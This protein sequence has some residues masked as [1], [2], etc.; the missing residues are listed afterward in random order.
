[1]EFW[2]FEGR[3]P[4]DYQPGREEANPD[5]NGGVTSNSGVTPQGLREMSCLEDLP[6]IMDGGLSPQLWG[7]VPLSSWISPRQ[8]PTQG[9]QAQLRGPYF[10]R[11]S[12]GY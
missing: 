8:C 1:M 4:R 10:V 11:R 9:V 5:V 2:E 6:S 12:F 3:R 7:H